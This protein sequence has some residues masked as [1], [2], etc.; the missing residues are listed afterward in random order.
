MLRLILLFLISF[1]VYSRSIIVYPGNFYSNTWNQAQIMHVQTQQQLQAQDL[2]RRQLLL[3]S[4]QWR[5]DRL[6]D[7]RISD[8]MRLNSLMMHHHSDRLKQY[9]RHR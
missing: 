3:Q 5:M 6:E 8:G 2:Y 7:Q 9:S 1:P 4:Q